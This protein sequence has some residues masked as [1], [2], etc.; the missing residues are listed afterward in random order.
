MPVFNFWR[1]FSKPALFFAILA[2]FSVPFAFTARRGYERSPANIHIGSATT[3]F[4]VSFENITDIC[5]ATPDFAAAKHWWVFVNSRTETGGSCGGGSFCSQ[6][7][8]VSTTSVSAQIFLPDR[9]DYYVA[10]T[11][12]SDNTDNP[13]DPNGNYWSPN[14]APPLEGSLDPPFNPIFNV[15]DAHHP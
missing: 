8:D 15:Q 14:T 11:F 1:T 5:G 12:C 13:N 9:S 3:T 4:S 10:G 7:F 6:T 2:F